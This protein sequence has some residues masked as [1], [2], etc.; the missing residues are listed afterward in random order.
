MVFVLFGEKIMMVFITLWVLSLFLLSAA[1][2]YRAK[3][4][5]INPDDVANQRIIA[6]NV[7]LCLLMAVG[8]VVKAGQNG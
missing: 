7:L 1:T 5:E 6:I 2:G 8:L 3:M 4:L